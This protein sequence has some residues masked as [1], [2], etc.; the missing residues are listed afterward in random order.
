MN[1]SFLTHL[2][3]GRA[4]VLQIAPSKSLEP[5]DRRSG[6]DRRHCVT[7]PFTILFSPGRRQQ[8]GRRQSDASNI[9]VD[10]YTPVLRYICVGILLLSTVDAFF[11]LRLID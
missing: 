10:C 2:L 3:H 8:N 11:T 4:N 6:L 7:H 9:Y 1:L 5:M